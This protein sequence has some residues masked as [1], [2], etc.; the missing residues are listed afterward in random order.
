MAPNKPLS[1]FPEIKDQR[2][3]KPIDEG[4]PVSQADLL[5][6]EQYSMSEH[7]LP[8]QRAIA[9]KVTPES[10]VGGF[11]LPGTRVD[12]VYTTRGGIES[13]SRIILQNMLVMAVDTQDQRADGIKSMLGQTVTLAATPEE[14]T[15]LSLAAS[16]GELRLL[17]K[18]GAD[19][20]RTY[21]VVSKSGDLQRPLVGDNDKE[22]EL[23]RGG[24]AMLALPE[25]KEEP[26]VEEPAPVKEKVEP[27]KKKRHVMTI[28]TG[29]TVE[30]ATFLLG[31][32]DD[33]DD[34]A[35]PMPTTKKEETEKKSAPPKPAPPP[36]APMPPV[37]TPS[38][39]GKVPTIRSR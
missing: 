6:K 5:T 9:I 33:E 37:S 24:T 39:S 16:G 17:L 13:S 30:K 38:P 8:G 4:K 36:P 15:R 18:N 12:V 28:R 32:T 31:Q 14:S 34:D 3:N 19:N 11:V 23:P 2:L 35:T 20:K 22:P 25:I 27:A 26:K 29:L 7:L 21:N 1:D 10:L